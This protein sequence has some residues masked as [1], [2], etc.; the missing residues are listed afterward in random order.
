MSCHYFYSQEVGCLKLKRFWVEYH[1][2][3]E[4]RAPECHCFLLHRCHLL[5]TMKTWSVKNTERVQFQMA[6]VHTPM[7]S[8]NSCIKVGCDDM[9]SYHISQGKQTCICMH[10]CGE[11]S[12]S[13]QS[14]FQPS[15]YSHILILISHSFFILS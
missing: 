10:V 9:C 3:S 4:F 8:L 11:G 7:Q 5:F 6:S 14:A 1:F 12:I 13:T 15:Q 2:T